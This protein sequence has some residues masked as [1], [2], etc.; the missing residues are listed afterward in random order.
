MD[1]SSRYRSVRFTMTSRL[2][3]P[4]VIHYCWFGNNPKN[5]LIRSC[6]DSWK[7]TCPDY[8]IIEWNES[9][10]DIASLPR[11]PRKAHED[12][13]WAFVSDYVRFLVLYESGG[14]YLDTDMLLVKSLDPL[15]DNSCFFGYESKNKINGAIIGAER[16]NEFIEK[17]IA[18]YD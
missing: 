14:I 6:M 12:K 13:K 1:S 9:N 11:Y 3:I 15:L 7:A 2:T 16:N 18:K 4:K 5:K 17:V 8:E 10:I